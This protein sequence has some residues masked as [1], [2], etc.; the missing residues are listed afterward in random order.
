MLTFNFHSPEEELKAPLF[1]EKDIQVFIKRDDMIHPYISGNKWR[2]LKYSLQEAQSTGKSTL[3]TFGGAWSNHLLATAAAAAKFGFKS[4]G[5]VRGEAV[6]NAVLSLCKIFGMQLIFV[7]RTAYKDKELLFDRQFG[8]D[9]QAFFIDEG[10]FGPL[11]AKGVSELMDELENNYQHIFCACGTG[12]T[13]AGLLQGLTSNSTTQIHGIPVLKAG[14]FIYEEVKALG[15]DP[16][17]V[18]LH[19]EYHFGGYA[20]TKPELIDFVKE[21]SQNTGILIEPTYTGKLFYGVYDLIKQDY[22]KPKSKILLIHSG[23]LTGLL[24]MLDK[25]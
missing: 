13:L 9:N 25:F 21:F 8:R 17:G 2:K 3:V 14:S 11:A 23:G 16:E 4:Y 15:I 5:F 10:G 1:Q 24:G 22:F 12:T 6:D 20:K 19:T 18:I 7:D